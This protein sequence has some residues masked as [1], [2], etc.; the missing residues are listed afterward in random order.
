MKK[1]RLF[2]A[3]GFSTTMLRNK[4]REAAL[5]SNLDFDIEA[6]S[7]SEI[8]NQAPQCDII[9]LGPQIRYNL[10][11]VKNDYPDKIVLLIDMQLY[12]NMDGEAVVMQIAKELEAKNE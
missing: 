11:R 2:C 5:A 4:M 10:N 1:I 9:L 12:A 7:Y 8:K 6:Y 3:H